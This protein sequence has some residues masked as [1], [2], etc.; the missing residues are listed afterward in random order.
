MTRAGR[1]RAWIIAA[2]VALVAVAAWQWQHD[3]AAAPGTLL[4]APPASISKV[5]LSIGSRPAEHYTRHDGHWW[6][7]DDGNV[8][9]DD[10]RLGELTDTA[11]AAVLSW[12]PIS[13]FEPARIGLAPPAAVLS[14]DGQRLEF[15]ETSVTGPQ[16]YV[17][18]GDRVA[19]VSVRYTPRPVSGQA[20]HAQ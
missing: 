9:A 6:R 12:R 1:Q 3:R 11:A 17:R 14:L 8:R 10:G 16:R 13:D 20:V 5:E 18:V 7:T 4:A 15:G 19:L 2:A